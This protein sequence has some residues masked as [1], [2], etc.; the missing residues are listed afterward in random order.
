MIQVVILP[1]LDQFNLCGLPEEFIPF[2]NG[3]LGQLLKRKL[4]HACEELTATVNPNSSRI[5]LYSPDSDH[6]S[7]LLT[8]I[9]NTC[10]FAA[11]TTQVLPC[12]DTSHKL[13][14]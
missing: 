11:T 9:Q 5:L 14:S 4:Y 7:Y 10:C 8:I 6:K 1:L 13:M 3:I 12:R 2:T